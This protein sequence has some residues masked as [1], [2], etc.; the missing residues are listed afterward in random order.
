MSEYPKVIRIGTMTMTVKSAAEEAK[1]RGGVVKDVPSVETTE[2]SQDSSPEVAPEQS[3][4]KRT[5][6][7][8]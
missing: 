2:P 4:T 3:K 6:K 5:K 1:W 7:A 8:K